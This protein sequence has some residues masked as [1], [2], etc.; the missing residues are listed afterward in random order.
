VLGK[1]AHDARIA[2]AMAVHGITHILAFNTV[3]FSRYHAVAAI[4]PSAV[5]AGTLP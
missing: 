4:N 1:P 5:V 3:D 2:A